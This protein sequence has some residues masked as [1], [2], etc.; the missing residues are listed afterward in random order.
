[1]TPAEKKINQAKINLFTAKNTTFFSTLLAQLRIEWNES[2]PTAGTDGIRLVINPNFI[3]PLSLKQTIGLLLHEVMHV[4]LEHVSRKESANLEKIRYNIAGDY[5]INGMLD[6][7]GYELPENGY[8]NHKYDTY[9][10]RQVYDDLEN[11]AIPKNFVV[12]ILPSTGDG[13][14]EEEHAERVITNIIKAVTQAKLNNDCGSIPGEI[15]IKVE[16]LTN[17]KLPWNVILQ[18]YMSSYNKDDYSWTKPNRKYWPEFYLPSAIG[19]NLDQITVGIDTSGS[20]SQ[21]DFD[22][23][24]AEV[25]YIFDILKPKKLRLMT[26]DTE[27]RDD[28]EFT[29]GDSIEGLTCFGGGGTDIHPLIKSIIEDS[30][31]IV[32]IFTD[33][34]FF[35]P[36][37]DSVQSD[38]FWIRIGKNKKIPT[39]G[40]LIEYN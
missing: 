2:F 28:K 12:D 20:I 34:E 10:T 9:S 22:A 8:I 13:D 30:P 19:E 15:L 38:L 24:I 5:V 7:W 6:N 29:E 35:M 31:D 4:A 18:E 17:P 26:F 32:L 27:V 1:M 11:I 3:E 16:E 33:M 37:L 25:S 21:K 23:F 36:N 39:K 14:N 40:I